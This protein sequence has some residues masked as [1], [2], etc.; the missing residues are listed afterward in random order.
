LYSVS[1]KIFGNWK[2]AITAAGLSYAEI[3]SANEL[4]KDKIKQAIVALHDSGKGFILSDKTVKL[5]QA[6]Y[7]NYSSVEDALTDA[8]V[9]PQSLPPITA[10]DKESVITKIQMLHK[11]GK[12]LQGN[13][14]YK[15]YRS[16]YF[17]AIYFFGT[18]KKTIIE[19]GI[20]YHSIY[21]IGGYGMSYTGKDERVYDS[22][23]E[24][25]V[26]DKL[27]ALKELGHIKDYETHVRVCEERH[28]T[29][30]FVLEFADRP[31]VWLEVDG[32][33]S[34]RAEGSYNSG[35]NAKIAH[36]RDNRFNY[37]VI[38]SEREVF[39]ILIK[40]GFITYI[41]P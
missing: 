3:K 22:I 27:F 36:Y 33:G 37:V 7:K 4:D 9:P 34:K 21:N 14:I 19:A 18:W 23:T 35:Y 30:D 13:T 5:L 41:S 11:N 29:C 39:T 26:A 24:G 6:I 32:M 1:C 12:K 16:M 25:K 40:K 10:W 2:N 15:T 8:G 20:D 31:N 38:R 28:W 17:A